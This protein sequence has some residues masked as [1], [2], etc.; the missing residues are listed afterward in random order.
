MLV[1]YLVLTSFGQMLSFGPLKSFGSS[2]SGLNSSTFSGF[3][4]SQTNTLITSLNAL[5][6]LNQVGCNPQDSSYSS[7]NIQTPWTAN[8]ESAPAHNDSVRYIRERYQL[9]SAN[10]STTCNT[11]TS[12][13]PCYGT[14][15]NYTDRVTQ[16]YQNITDILKVGP[17]MT[18]F[19]DGMKANM[20]ELTTYVDGFSNQTRNLVKKFDKMKT[21]TTSQLIKHVDDFKV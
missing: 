11:L 12:S 7:S 3:D 20:T 17:D 10:V 18:A 21:G 19:L 6:G 5:T 2:V 8:G 4:A 9:S 14:G 1:H 15:C 16:L 13:A